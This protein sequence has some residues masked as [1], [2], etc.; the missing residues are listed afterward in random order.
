[1]KSGMSF[2]EIYSRYVQV[3]EQ[4]AQE[5]AEN[6]RLHQYIQS[7]IQ[8]LEHKGPLVAKQREH[9]EKA[10]D[11]IEDL[12]KQVERLSAENQQMK[13]VSSD[14]RRSAGKMQI[15]AKMLVISFETFFHLILSVV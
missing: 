4:V 6:K 2:T 1:M 12:T 15:S 9:Y 3:T 5:R 10:M 13:E 7:I 14:L 8:E 11:S